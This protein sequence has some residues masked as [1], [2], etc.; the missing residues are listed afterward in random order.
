MYDYT[1]ALERGRTSRTARSAPVEV[2]AGGRDWLVLPDVFSPVAGQS[3]RTHLGLLDF[4]AGGSFLEIGA[5]TGVIAVSAAL[6]GCATVVATDLN[7][8]AVENTTHN[9]RR[10]GVADR[11]TSLQGD[12]FDTLEPGAR[13]DVVYWH[14]NNVWTPSSLDVDHVHELAYV[15]PGYAAHQRFLQDAPDHVAP[16]GRILLGISSRASRDDLD[17]L[18]AKENQRLRSVRSAVVAE[19]EGPV[20]YELLHVQPEGQP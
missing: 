14:S 9:A 11:V 18:A 1:Q 2:S 8:A 6:A 13:F 20:V 12:M 16:G 15:D 5:G 4:P 19:P 17:I 7:P 10:H 3:T